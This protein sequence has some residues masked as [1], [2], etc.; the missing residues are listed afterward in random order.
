MNLSAE[1]HDALTEM[2][3]IG[4]GHSASTLNA[5]IHHKIRLSVPQIEIVSIEKMRNNIP[6]HEGNNIS[7][8][9]MGFHGCFDGTATLMFPLNAAQILVSELI[10]EAS[11]L[12]ELDDLHSSTLAEVGNI[13]LNG[14]M[15]SL[16]NVLAS[17]LDYSVPVY[18]EISMR[19]MFAH[20]QAETVLIA[21]AH[22]YID[23]LCV[24]GNVVLF[25]DLKAFH[26]LIDAIDGRI[27]A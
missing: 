27:M 1:Q 12:T 20:Q 16:S 3:N 17:K 14:V 11:D 10:D 9:S 5:L 8:V 6:I 26:A 18:Q 24:E 2:I 25:F 15:G 19:N 7:S 21:R 23:E 4:I 13:L 22:F